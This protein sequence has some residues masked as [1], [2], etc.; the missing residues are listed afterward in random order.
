MGTHRRRPTRT[1]FGGNSV[2]ALRVVDPYRVLRRV[3]GSDE[4]PPVW[5]HGDAFLAFF[6]IRT[7]GDLFRLA[8]GKTLAPQVVSSG[9]LSGKVH[10]FA[11]GGPG[12]GRARRADRPDLPPGRSSG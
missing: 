4:R 5:R 2:F 3:D 6:C 7:E 9:D 12:H 11:V 1:A 10:P 8:G